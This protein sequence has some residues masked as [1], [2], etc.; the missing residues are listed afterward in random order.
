M[1]EMN[2]QSTLLIEKTYAQVNKVDKTEHSFY[3]ISV[4]D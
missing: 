1:V 2:I 3:F 4:N